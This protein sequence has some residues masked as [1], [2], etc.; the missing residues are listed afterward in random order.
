M[1]KHDVTQ[2]LCPLCQQSNTCAVESGE[3][4]DACWCTR[5]TFPPKNAM[6]G[7]MPASSSCICEAC[8]DKLNQQVELGI[9][10]LD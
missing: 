4:I 2:D 5:V 6:L 7:A 3:P 8:I 9:K 10:R 1:N